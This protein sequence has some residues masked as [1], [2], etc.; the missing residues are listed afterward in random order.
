MGGELVHLVD[1]VDLVAPAGR[2]VLHVLP[3][4]ADLVDAPVGGA[5]DL[6]HVDDRAGLDFAADRARST[7]IR[8]SPLGTEQGLGQ[9]PGRGGLAH[10]A[11]T[12][13]EVGM[14]DAPGRQRVAQRPR[15]RVLPDDRL[16]RLRPPL[17][18]ED[19]ITQVAVH[20]PPNGP[21][22]DRPAEPAPARYSHG[23]REGRLTVAPFRAWRGSTILVA[24]GPAFNAAP[25]GSFNTARPREGIRPR[26]SGLRAT[27]HRY[28]PV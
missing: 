24:W 18:R 22:C 16:K 7:G 19:L 13:E 5:V 10:S 15:D 3:Q 28:L 14:S 8:A 25:R 4:R 1:D 2:R 12:G 11:G 6:D 23:T 17:P 9:Q 20:P 26:W 27:G 21:S